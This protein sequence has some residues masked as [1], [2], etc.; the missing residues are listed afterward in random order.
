MS[1]M[2]CSAWTPTGTVQ[3]QV[4][5]LQ[6]QDS[7]ACVIWACAGF[8]VQAK[9][10]GRLKVYFYDTEAGSRDIEPTAIPARASPQVLLDPI[11]FRGTAPLS[12]S[13]IGQCL[14]RWWI[15]TAGISVCFPRPLLMKVALHCLQGALARPQGMHANVTPFQTVHACGRCCTCSGALM[16]RS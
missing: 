16:G 3:S 13:I 8:P 4:W 10:E 11:G 1:S 5:L 9:V 7:T 2:R 12:L 14:C 6:H 15:A